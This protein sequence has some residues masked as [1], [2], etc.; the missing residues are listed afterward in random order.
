MKAIYW[1]IGVSACGLGI[2]IYLFLGDTQKSLP[3][4]KLSYFVDENEIAESVDKILAQEISK[5]DFYWIGIEPDK[6]EQL[7]V[8]LK[9][10][11]QLEKNKPFRTVIVDQELGL[12]KEWLEK[13]KA[14]EV[15]SVKEN[16]TALTELLGQLEKNKERYLLITASIYSTPLILKNQIHQMKTAKSIFPMTFSLAYFPIKAEYESRMLFSCNTEDHA[17]TSDWGCV[18]ANKSR[19]IR[20]RIDEKN[21]KPWIGVMDLIGEKD[22][23]LLL[24]KK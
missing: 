1:V 24:F 9:L 8:V 21:V 5:Q 13:L 17:G 20:R 2:F 10:K 18:V 19:F 22:Y 15:T 6:L 4:I 7:E 16:M 14:V 11:Q 3:K 12:K 23:M